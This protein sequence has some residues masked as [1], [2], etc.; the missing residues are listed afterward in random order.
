MKLLEYV[1]VGGIVYSIWNYFSYDQYYS[2]NN[3]VTN[4]E[5]EI[6]KESLPEKY[7]IEIYIYDTSN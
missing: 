1:A 4:T 5:I 7:C 6:I 2:F 3:K